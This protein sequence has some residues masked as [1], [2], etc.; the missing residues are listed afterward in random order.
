MPF[1]LRLK[2]SKQYNVVTKTVFVICVELLDNSIVEC[3]LSADSLGYDCL[4]NVCQRLGLNQPEFFGLRYVSQKS[5][6][7]VRWVELDRPLK[8][9]LD[10]HA[11]EAY[12][13]LRIMYYVNDVSLLED[14]MTR[15]HYFLQLKSDVMEGRL[16][17]SYNE[18]VVLA[19]YRLQAE[20]GDHDP[21]R[22]TLQYLKEFVLVP[23]HLVT[24]ESQLD[25]VT[26]AVA[27]QHSKLLGFPQPVAECW[28]IVEAQHLDGYGQERF[29]AKEEPAGEALVATSLQ[30]IL[31]MRNNTERVVF[32]RWDDITNLL[33]QKRMFGI[34]C[35]RSEENVNFYFDDPEAA[36]YVWKLAVLQH[37]FYKQTLLT[38]Q[39]L[40]SQATE[41][42]DMD[43]SCGIAGLNLE[44]SSATINSSLVPSA[45]MFESA[46][47]RSSSAMAEY[48]I[49]SLGSVRASLPHSVSSP[50]LTIGNPT[51]AQSHLLAGTTGNGGGFASGAGSLAASQQNLKALLPAYRPAPDYE[52]AQPVQQPTSV[53]V[54]PTAT[55]AFQAQPQHNTQQ[56]VQMIKMYKPP[57]PYPYS[58]VGSNSSPDLVVA[59]ING[60]A[61]AT[62]GSMSHLPVTLA[63]A[64]NSAMMRN[65]EPIYQNIPLRQPGSQPNLSP[66]TSAN[67]QTA[68]QPRRKWGLPVRSSARSA[69]INRVQTESPSSSPA[70][71]RSTNNSTSNSSSNFHHSASSAAKASSTDATLVKDHLRQEMESRLADGQLLLE[72]ELIPRRKAGA[73]FSMAAHPDNLCRN[74]YQ[75]VLP[76]EEN[77]VKLTPSRD[78]RTGYINASH[79]SAAVGSA[80]RF[81]IAAQGPLP[82]TVSDFWQMV[83]QCDVYVIVMLADTTSSN[84]GGHQTPLLNTKSVNALRSHVSHSSMN[85]YSGF[86]YWPQQDAATLEFGE[87]KI[88]RQ[89]SKLSAGR[90]SIT[91]LD[92]MHLPTSQQRSIWHLQYSDWADHGCPRDV[93]SFLSFLEEMDMVRRHAVSDVPVGKNRNTPVLVHCGAGVGRTGVTVACDVLLTSLDHNV[94]V[95]VPKLITHLRQ[96]RMLMVQ[97]VAQYRSIYALL[98]AYLGR[99]RLI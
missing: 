40:Q 42:K 16:R 92:V 76:Y 49:D 3:T 83:W 98:L 12:L 80:Q 75:D 39:S 85:G 36:R 22:H 77:R 48:R 5:Y 72:F 54:Q 47:P 96:Q 34:E 17:C 27:A 68:S 37:T 95:D 61:S 82:S 93:T 97:T 32:Y 74:Q 24:N 26:E 35:Q 13:Y 91:K 51:Q 19:G 70:S 30:G 11:Q 46:E 71:K 79:I 6:P 45:S 59:A 55:S 29:L 60:L 43:V 8:K 41:D 7:R 73:D 67:T 14:E 38:L 53:A 64:E 81:Y 65:G 89:V 88:T 99:S 31:V 1:K 33:N 21:E 20:F 69:V 62:S 28:Y 52:T 4:D 44:P 23:K 56:Q 25:A 2:K 78:N 63:Q 9:Q 57:P 10:K 87:Y 86:T 94:V 18:A 66:S 58:K 84:N 50:T 15:Y 90:Q